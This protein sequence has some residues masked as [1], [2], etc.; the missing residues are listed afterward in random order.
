MIARLVLQNNYWGYLFS[1]VRVQPDE[2]FHS[3]MG[4]SVENDGTISL[5]YKES[6]VNLTNDSNLEKFLVHEGLHLLNQHLPRLLRII[7]DEVNEQVI[8]QKMS[9]FN[10]AADMAVNSQANL[11]TLY[12]DDKEYPLIIPESFNLPKKQVTEWY[13]LELLKQSGAKKKKN[14]PGQGGSK[15]LE[16][17]KNNTRKSHSRWRTSGVSDYRALSRKAEQFTRRI[18]SESKRSFSKDRG[19][20]PSYITELISE[21]LEPPKLPYYE[22]IKKLVVGSRFTKFKV[23]PTR[24]NRKRTYAIALADKEDIV[25]ILPFPGK[26]RDFSFNIV[27][28]LD[29]SGSMSKDEIKEGLSSVKDII[30]HDR[31]CLTTVLEVDTEIK[32]EY[33]VKKVD[34]IQFKIKGRGGTILGPGL[35]RAKELDC[36]VCLAFTDGYVENINAYPREKLPKRMIWVVSKQGVIDNINRSGFAVQL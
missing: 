2:S 5:Y 23:S 20:L 3:A 34:D 30:Q 32:K 4:V 13:Y 26:T 1:L 29:T 10:I 11:E 25:P 15:K 28:L 17:C 8:Q 7:G 27:V 22:L 9:L 6:S 18:V 14:M 19:K 21:L 31:Y 12:I 24:I 36:D 35:F 33:V 16:Q